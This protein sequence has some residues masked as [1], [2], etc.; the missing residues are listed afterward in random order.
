MMS[1]ND[2][3]PIIV[4]AAYR[5]RTTHETTSELAV[6]GRPTGNEAECRVRQRN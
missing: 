1:V 3:V 2:N 4:G 5:L 6:S